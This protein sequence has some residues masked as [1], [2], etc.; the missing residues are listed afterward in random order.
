MNS[1]DK[2]MPVF[3]ILTGFSNG[4]YWL[5]YSTYVSAFTLDSRWDVALAFIGFVNGKMCIRDRA[6]IM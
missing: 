5:T 1:A 4:F 2:M 3:G 6:T